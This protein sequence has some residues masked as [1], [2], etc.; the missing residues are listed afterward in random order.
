MGIHTTIIDGYMG[1]LNNLSPNDKLELISKLSTSSKANLK[2]RK[3]KFKSAFGAME[4]SKTAE[5][6]IKELKEYRSF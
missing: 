5:E 6:I 4:T 2:P 3:N 1:L